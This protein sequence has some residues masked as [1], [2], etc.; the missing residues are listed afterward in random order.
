[1]KRLLPIFIFLLLIISCETGTN[2]SRVSVNPE[3]NGKISKGKWNK[4]FTLKCGGKDIPFQIYFPKQFTLGKPSMTL[5]LLHDYGKNKREFEIYSRIET[6]AEKYNV[7]L[8][9]PSMGNSIYATKYFPETTSKWNDVPGTV[10][11][12]E[13]FIPHLTKQFGLAAS[14]QLTG[15]LGVGNGGHGAVMV[16][17]TY[18]QKIGKVSAIDGYYDFLVMTRNRM[19]KSVYGD[20]RSN[21]LRWEKE[22]NV[23]D[24]VI[25]ME[26]TK[27]LL[28]HGAK[29]FLYRVEHARM[30]AIKMNS[31]SKKGNYPF[32]YIEKTRGK[33]EWPH[34][35]SYLETVFDYLFH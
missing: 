34:W 16:A 26:N 1:M 20:Y 30:L 35:N 9:A 17:S 11:I 23:F 8:V 24:K 3:Y 6:L 22:D 14:K 18:P 21:K 4:G 5:I 19:L 28:I 2:I 10:F 31:L 27:F 15:I 7:A 32:K 12:G 33:Y 29:S 25:S 13:Y